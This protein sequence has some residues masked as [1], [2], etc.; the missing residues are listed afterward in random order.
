MPGNTANGLPYPL[1]SEPVR[2]GAVAIRNL[3]EELTKRAVIATTTRGAVVYVRQA[4]TSNAGGY[5]QYPLPT[6]LSSVKGM[7]IIYEGSFNWACRLTSYPNAAG[8][9]DMQLVEAVNQAPIPNASFIM[10]SVIWGDAV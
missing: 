2:D 3:A 10:N 1:P 8:S 4:L 6:G 5:V 7:I 9:F